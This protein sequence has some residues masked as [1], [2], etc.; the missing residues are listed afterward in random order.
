[1]ASVLRPPS[2]ARRLTLPLAVAA[3][4]L[5]LGAQAFT[6]GTW[7]AKAPMPVARTG[8]NSG[9][10]DGPDL[11]DRWLDRKSLSS[12]CSPTTPSRISGPSPRFQ[13]TPQTIGAAGVIDG[14][15]DACRWNQWLLRDQSARPS[16]P[17]ASMEAVAAHADGTPGCHGRCHR[18]QALRGRRLQLEW[19][20]SDVDGRRPGDVRPGDER[21]DD[22]PAP[23]PTAR[24]WG[25]AEVVNGK[26]YVAGGRLPDHG[27]RDGR[28]EMYD[29]TRTSGPRWRPCHGEI[30]P[31]N[32]RSRRHPLRH[33]WV[34]PPRAGP[35]AGLLE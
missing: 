5:L 22:A 4:S 23:M 29:P 13:P 24:S 34:R 31:V 33:R 21:M 3:V 17:P 12:T 30:V 25:G 35:N 7:V 1:M 27:S 11:H 20:E 26:L 28:S 8:L 16:R 9:V 2:A 15:L 32:G 6:A 18:R 14:V 10:I 19:I